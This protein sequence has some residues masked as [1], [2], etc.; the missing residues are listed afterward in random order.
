VEP[1]AS[2]PEGADP[3]HRKSGSGNRPWYAMA[4]RLRQTLRDGG[5]FEAGVLHDF[6]PSPLSG[7]S[8]IRPARPR[9]FVP[10][11]GPAYRFPAFLCPL[12]RG[13]FFRCGPRGPCKGIWAFARHISMVIRAPR[14]KSLQAASS[15]QTLAAFTVVAAALLDPFQ[16]AIGI[17]CL[18]GIIL[19]KAGP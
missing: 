17:G 9:T 1:P 15:S 12:N 6:S 18:I 13:T 4:R 3:S 16:T 8:F 19:V 2:G 14:R 7:K 11:A 10:A 5:V